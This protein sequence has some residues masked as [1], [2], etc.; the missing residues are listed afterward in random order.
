MLDEDIHTH[1]STH[2]H[3]FMN[4]RGDR[5][6]DLQ[7][8]ETERGERTEESHLGFSSGAKSLEQEMA[9]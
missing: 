6:N 4:G 7:K 2:T 1:I 5:A 9:I 3:T 8:K